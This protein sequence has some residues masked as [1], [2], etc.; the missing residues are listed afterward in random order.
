LFFSFCEICEIL[1]ICFREKVEKAQDG[2]WAG[3]FFGD[4]CQYVCGTHD[5]AS[6]DDAQVGYVELAFVAQEL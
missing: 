6:V 4:R 3:G 5:Q 2:G 1:N